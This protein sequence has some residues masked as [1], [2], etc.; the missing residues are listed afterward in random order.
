MVVCSC[1]SEDLVELGGTKVWEKS[2]VQES[3]IVVQALSSKFAQS[4]ID[5]EGAADWPQGLAETEDAEFRWS[6]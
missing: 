5:A 2:A 1:G 6:R 3:G 4:S